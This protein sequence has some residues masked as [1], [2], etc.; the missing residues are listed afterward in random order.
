[1]QAFL[2]TL[3][4]P[5]NARCEICREVPASGTQTSI[6][7]DIEA[8]DF[9]LQKSLWLPVDNEGVILERG[10]TRTTAG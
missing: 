6:I 7:I 1:M 2:L 8:V 10:Q 3:T 9:G 5:R 4:P